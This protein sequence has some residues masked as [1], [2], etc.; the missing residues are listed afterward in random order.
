MQTMYMPSTEPVSMCPA[1][2]LPGDEWEREVISTFVDLRQVRQHIFLSDF[3]L[4][5][6][7]CVR[8]R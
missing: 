3:L 1:Y 7:A 6:G 2:L 8:I 4:G 5:V